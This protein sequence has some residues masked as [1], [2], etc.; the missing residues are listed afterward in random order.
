MTLEEKLCADIKDSMKKKEME[1]LNTLRL[2]KAA[3]ENFKIQKNT[4][5]LSDEQVLEIIT[6]QVKQRRESYESFQKAGREELASKE[7][8]E[9]KLLSV[10]L[11]EPLSDE[12][13]QA[14][15]KTAISST[16]AS[17]KADAGKVMKAVMPKLKGKADGKRI[18][19]IV[20]SLLH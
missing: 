15:V 6:K 5:K 8:A 2:V 3:M 11:P 16:S 13:I 9:I 20:M 1:K 18:N 4:E 14:E 17:V 7:N 12:A 10:Y 19:A